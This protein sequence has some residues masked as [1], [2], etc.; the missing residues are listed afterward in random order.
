MINMHDRKK[1]SL[2]QI[3]SEAWP[4]IRDTA[5]MPVSVAA[6]KVLDSMQTPEGKAKLRAVGFGTVIAFLGGA[7]EYVSHGDPS[8]AGLFELHHYILPGAIGAAG[9]LMY[10]R[11]C[12]DKIRSD[13]K[14]EYLERMSNAMIESISDHMSMVDRDLN[15]IWANDVTKKTFGADILG[16]KCYSAYHGR[17]RPCEPYP[18]VTLRSF[19]D[20]MTHDQDTSITDRSGARKDFHCVANVALRDEHGRPDAVLEIARD[21]TGQRRLQDNLRSSE[22]KLKTIFDSLTTGI[23]LID[24]EEQRIVDANRSACDMVG[25]H[26]SDMVG[27]RRTDYLESVKPCVGVSNCAKG[28]SDYDALLMRVDGKSLPVHRKTSRLV[29]DGRDCVLETLTDISERKKIEN[30][31]KVRN[32]AIEASVSPI[33]LADLEG[34]ITYANP[35][36]LHKW[37]IEDGKEIIGRYVTDL[38]RMDGEDMLGRLQKDGAWS[39]ELIAKRDEHGA[40]FDVYASAAAVKDDAGVPVCNMISFVDITERKKIEDLTRRMAYEDSLTGLANRRQIED[41]LHKEISFA[42]RKGTMVFVMYIDIDGF[43]QVND[44][45]GHKVGDI[46]LK[47]CAKEFNSCVRKY[48]TV[49]RVGGDEFLIV[50]P[51]MDQIKEGAVISKRILDRFREPILQLGTYEISV[52][53]SIGISV[54]P[55]DVASIM[56]ADRFYEL[57][58]KAAADALIRKADLTMYCSKQAG[59]NRYRF[60]TPS[61]GD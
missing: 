34:R 14:T 13:R 43:K 4:T 21:I 19:E 18:C 55:K 49:G 29:I 60:Y 7:M 35:A 5:N 3:L 25:G 23:L 40:L 9:G 46:L 48:D 31:L 27:K 33:A 1:H 57:N 59:K 61:L 53:P 28:I 36:F 38:L 11:I 2:D 54:F 8:I 30:E 47:V 41:V 10:N 12:Q 58:L 6:K 20:E 15:I 42:M 44:S 45:Y 56:S 16:R 24:A 32:Y 26:I 51:H 37:E 17:D 52:T 22:E 50:F 39:G